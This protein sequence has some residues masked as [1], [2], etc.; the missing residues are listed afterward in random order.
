MTNKRRLAKTF[1]YIN[2]RSNPQVLFVTANESFGIQFENADEEKIS[3]ELT[4]LFFLSQQNFL[5][6]IFF[7]DYPYNVL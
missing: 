4:I 5:H 1:P 7:L 3:F 6:S 2:E